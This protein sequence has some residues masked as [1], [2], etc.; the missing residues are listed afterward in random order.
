MRYLL[1]VI[2]ITLLCRLHGQEMPALSENSLPGI[3]KITTRQFGHD[4][5]WG[6]INGGADL[7][8]EYGFEKLVTHQIILN[9][10]EYKADIY[11]MSSPEA[12]FGIYSVFRFRCRQS[13]VLHVHDCLTPYQYLAAKG[14]YYL[15][16]SNTRG[17]ET[18]IQ[19]SLAIAGKILEQLEN[20]DFMHPAAFDS[21]LLAPHMDNLKL[22]SGPLGLQNGYMKWDRMFSG[23]TGF[24]ALILPLNI[25]E[26]ACVIA[27]I[28]F[29][30]QES[31][32]KFLDQNQLVPANPSQLQPSESAGMY[33]FSENDALVIFEGKLSG[34][35][36]EFLNSLR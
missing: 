7:Y 26:S 18:E 22:V 31:Q 17:S 20:V 8:L 6:Y 15:S 5:L 4:G 2:A 11:R 36:I 1:L 33:V 13:G 3:T 14:K 23:F 30:S 16:V 32:Q 10:S 21:D 35:A 28:H 12:A 19:N 24:T 34:A 27:H 29:E 9:G 25:D